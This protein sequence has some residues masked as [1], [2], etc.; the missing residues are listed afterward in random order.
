MTHVCGDNLEYVFE[1]VAFSPYG[2]AD[3]V[4]MIVKEKPSR[5]VIQMINLIGNNDYWNQL[6]KEPACIKD[7]IVKVQIDQGV[8]NVFVASPD[9]C[10]GRSEKLAYTV[11]AGER[12]KMVIVK[13]PMLKIWSTLVIELQE[14]II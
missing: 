2:E 11:I 4:W 1:N 3:K 9:S 13:I 6:K 7:I 5:K 14:E 12:G 8:K 10:M